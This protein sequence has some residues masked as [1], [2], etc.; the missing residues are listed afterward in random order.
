MRLLPI[1]LL[2]CACEATPEFVEVDCGTRT[3]TVSIT[4]DGFD[5]R[6]AAVP[7]NAVVRW[8]NDDDVT[9][10][11]TSGSPGAEDEGALF[12]SASLAAGESFCL[13]VRDVGEYRY[14]STSGGSGTLEVESGSSGGNDPGN[15]PYGY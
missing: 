13:Q 11:V 6:T 14:F 12:D 9:H 8:D 1:L 5:P 2:L 7:V 10:T 15:D 3:A 4:T